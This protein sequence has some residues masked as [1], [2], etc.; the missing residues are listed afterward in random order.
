MVLIGT[1]YPLILE[2]L[3]LGKISVG[4]PYFNFVI[5]F[6][7]IPL[8]ISI[9]VAVFSNWNQGQKNTMKKLSPIILGAI[10]L[11]VMIPSIYGWTSLLTLV[12]VSLAFWTILTGISPFIKNKF[13]IN[14][15]LIYMPM[16]LGHIGLGLMI[17][18]I[19]VTSS[20]G[21]TIDDSMSIEQSSSVGDYEFK[22]TEI[23]RRNGP[24]YLAQYASIE[25]SKDGEYIETVY[26]EKRVYDSSS[27]GM[28][29]AGIEA[30]L[31]RDL[32]IAVGEDIG[33]GSWS[34]HLQYKPLLRLIWYGPI[35]MML[36]GFVRV[37]LSKKN[38]ENYQ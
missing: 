7:F 22:L 33:G 8:L 18:G 28:T 35:V 17:L 36:G 34:M 15:T 29:E 3:D 12:G 2:M 31:F 37:Y 1:V 6:P 25:I 4:P 20:Y 38:L 10:L 26:P 16:M 30:N 21:I 5:L 32:F 14:K 9:G 13:S 11:G 23:G 27:M 19:T 24:N